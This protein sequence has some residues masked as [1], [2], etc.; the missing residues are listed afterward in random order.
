MSQTWADVPADVLAHYVPAV[1]APDGRY[2]RI[3]ELLTT[4]DYLD[5]KLLR[6]GMRELLEDLRT[7]RRIAPND[8]A[9]QLA[10]LEV[11][12]GEAAQILEQH[13][14][15]LRGQL[16]ARIPR[17]A[18]AD[19]EVL[20]EAAAGWRGRAWWRPL[21]AVHSYGHLA[22][23]GPVPGVVDAMA[24]SDDGSV[25]LAGDREGGLHAWDVARRER[26][27]SRS[28]GCAVNAIAFRP[29]SFE[30][31]LALNDG[32]VARWSPADSRL[33]RYQEFEERAASAVAVGP[34]MLVC[35]GGP[36]VR[37][38]RVGGDGIVWRASAGAVPVTAVAVTGDGK[39]C[40][41]GASDGSLVLRR[42][43]DGRELRRLP[44]PVDR[45]V[46]LAALP[47][48]E[49]VVVGGK[50]KRVVAVDVDTG[51][52]RTI[53]RH[54][55]QV[56]S[57]VAF[58]ERRVV[59]GSYDGQVLM[60]DV[61][62]ATSRRIGAHSGWCLAVATPRGGGTVATGS[63]DG[64]L[65]LW[66]PVGAPLPPAD[67]KRRTRSLVVVGGI[68]YG[69]T[70]R[71]VHRTDVRTGTPLPRLTGHR[72]N[73]EALVATAHGVASGSA[74]RTIR[75]WQPGLDRPRVLRGHE[76]AVRALTVTPSGTEIVSVSQDGTWRRWQAGTG[77]AGPVVRGAD[78]Y[79]SVLVLSPDGELV[80]TATVEHVIEVWHR[81]SGRPLAM[82]AGHAGYVESLVAVPGNRLLV[83]GSWDRTVRVWDL[84]AGTAVW[85]LPCEE[86]V[87]DVAATAD[88]RLVAAYCANGT[89]LLV[90]PVA[91]A[92]RGTLVLGGEDY[93]R[94]ALSADDRTLFALRSYEVQA[95]DITSGARLATFDADLPLRRLAVAGPDT[96]VVGTELGTLVTMRLERA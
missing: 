55:N 75:V 77:E 59:T 48:G 84:V 74:D 72:G 33:R 93:G 96:V 22:A 62:V 1:L 30:A 49:T 76:A 41:S 12:L 83:S 66:D 37:G 19:L 28:V 16:L 4:V 11:A 46:C 2:A 38:G 67:S 64:R 78:P 81:E 7:A 69:G 80:V 8:G 9:A 92:V 5:Q 53:G 21:G 17:P 44:P 23:L 61:E 29:D 34:D 85:T 91:R 82:L 26:F 42:L 56:R 27:W 71:A 51:A 45:V 39:R 52:A 87:V 14:E 32:I 36:E 25:L 35:S 79:N 70:D 58:D 54:R 86:W 60:W 65:R 18:A 95:W 89:V 50:D 13:P 57:A 73:V 6:V 3:R 63:G 47:G 68:A 94:L 10:P 90:D 24:F 43:A 40:L 88:A 20:L 15:Q 31:F